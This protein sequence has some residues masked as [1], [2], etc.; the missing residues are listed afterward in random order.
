MGTPLTHARYLRRHRGSYG[1][2]TAPNKWPGPKTPIDGLLQ[3][4][5]STFPGIGIPAASASGLI[6][7]NTL[8]PVSAQLRML[9]AM[10]R[11]I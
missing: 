3:C 6:A 8:L 5:D 9:D 10:G 4:G 7:A 2:A 1:P 11:R